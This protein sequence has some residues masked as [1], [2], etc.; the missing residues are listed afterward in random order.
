MKFVDISYN[1]A[2]SGLT[3]LQGRIDTSVSTNSSTFPPHSAGS[4]QV[5]LFLEIVGICHSSPYLAFQEHPIYHCFHKLFDSL[6]FRHSPALF[7]EYI[8]SCWLLGELFLQSFLSFFVS[9]FYV[10]TPSC[11]ALLY[12]YSCLKISCSAGN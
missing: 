11:P 12:P 9:I 2:L 7:E 5:V 8:Q 1:I 6:G 10:K 3:E 4:T